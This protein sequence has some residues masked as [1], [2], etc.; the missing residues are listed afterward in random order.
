VLAIASAAVRHVKDASLAVEPGVPDALSGCLKCRRGS[1]AGQASE[2]V[3]I[4]AGVDLRLPQGLKE[5]VRWVRR[6]V[7]FPELRCSGTRRL[8]RGRRAQYPSTESARPPTEVVFARPPFAV[9]TL[10]R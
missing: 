10:V 9:P 4:A 5:R 3:T 7:G 8:L 1:I 6:G 2:A